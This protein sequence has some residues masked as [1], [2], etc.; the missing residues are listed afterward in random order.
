MN[1][2]DECRQERG[3]RVCAGARLGNIL[4]RYPVRVQNAV[5]VFVARR[6]HAH[7]GMV[8]V[9]LDVCTNVLQDAG[10]DIGVCEVPILVQLERHQ[11]ANTVA[12]SI[13]E[14]HVV[15]LALEPA[16]DGVDAEPPHIGEVALVV[17]GP[18]GCVERRVLWV[19]PNPANRF[20]YPVH[21][22]LPCAVRCLLDGDR[23]DAARRERVS[24]T[25]EPSSGL[26]IGVHR[27]RRG[28]H[29]LPVRLAERERAD[30]R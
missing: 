8:A 25:A 15:E 26:M 28:R 5:Q 17:R 12:G 4:L 14:R 7:R 9:S 2:I 22:V 29:N 18:V 21:Q 30:W 3:E 27:K 13:I 23:R 24:V 1:P 11:H 16:L 20:R 10:L 19:V 6:P